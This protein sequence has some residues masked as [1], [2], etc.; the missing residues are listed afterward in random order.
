MTLEATGMRAGF[1]AGLAV[2]LGVIGA[3]DRGQSAVADRRPALDPE[4]QSCRDAAINRERSSLSLVEHAR[5][6][7]GVEII[8]ARHEAAPTTR[9]ALSLDAGITAD[10]ADRLG[11]ATLMANLLPRGSGSLD[12]ASFVEREK[13]LGVSI[14]ARSSLDR[15]IIALSAPT[16]N[17][18][19]SLD[20]LADV[21]LHPALTVAEFERARTRQMAAIAREKDIPGAITSRT[22]LAALYGADHPYARPGY[23]TEGGVRALTPGD[24]QAFHRAWF[25]PEKATLFV[26]SDQPLATVKPLLE[27]RLGAWRSTGK[28]GVKA[29]AMATPPPRSRVILVDDK[30]SSDTKILGG[31]LLDGKTPNL[32]GLNAVVQILADHPSSRINLDI[33]RAKGWSP[34]V[35]ARI[36]PKAGRLAYTIS[37]RLLTERTGAAI[38]AMIEHHRGILSD[39]SVTA[40]ELEAAQ[41]ADIRKSI[42][43]SRTAEDVL[44]AIQEDALL[45]LPDDYRATLMSRICRQT[46][47]ALGRVARTHLDPARLTWVVVGDAEKIEPQLGPLGLSVE[48]LTP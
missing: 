1:F 21:I 35:Y 32:P 18:K 15:T 5:L 2:L 4:S 6:S 30:D 23:G 46:T 11:A 27:A 26:V 39:R 45:D 17:L 37:A 9:I 19:P 33:T 42:D 47:T 16:G 48:K 36:Y 8:Y 13:A 34:G 7:N 20:L 31:V 25:R 3:A 41:A 10:P 38:A 24:L 29:V 28:A 43:A 12:A 14:N 44:R 40:A 22:L